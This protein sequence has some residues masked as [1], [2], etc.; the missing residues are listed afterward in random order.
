MYRKV[1][2]RIMNPTEEMRGM[3]DDP[4][5]WRIMKLSLTA[6]EDLKDE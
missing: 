2:G 4:P 1:Q 3:R 6:S 5:M